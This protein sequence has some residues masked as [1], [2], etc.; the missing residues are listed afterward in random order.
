[1]FVSSFANVVV[2]DTEEGLVLVDT[3]SFVT[4]QAVR[5]AVQGFSDRPVHTAIYTHGH[6]DHVMGMAVFETG[7]HRARVVAHEAVPARFDRYQL[8]AGYNGAITARQ[9]RMP[10][11]TWPTD[12]RY[13]D[14]TY[15]RELDLTVGGERLSLRHARGETD[16]HTWVWLPER[17]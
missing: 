10:G 6:V 1:A 17:R 5:S 12:Y 7:G 13:P 2:L 14:E 4:A 8:T 16:D 11:L 3:S 15:A 9:F